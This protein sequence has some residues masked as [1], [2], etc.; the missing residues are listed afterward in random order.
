[1]GRAA[2]VLHGDVRREAR[3][4]GGAGGWGRVAAEEEG[5]GPANGRRRPLAFAGP[6][7]PTPASRRR[8]RPHPLPHGFAPRYSIVP[9][10]CPSRQT[11]RCLPADDPANA[12]WCL[13]L[14]CPI[15]RPRRVSGVHTEHSL[16]PQYHPQHCWRG[17]VLS[18]SVCRHGKA[19]GSSRSTH[20][21]RAPAASA[22]GGASAKRQ[23]RGKHEARPHP[24]APVK[25]LCMTVPRLS[26]TGRS[27]RSR[28]SEAGSTPRTWY[29]VAPTSSGE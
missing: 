11:R 27:W 7:G 24:A 15:R 20:L 12:P 29:T 28:T 13:A 21:R 23:A 19:G 16:W 22:S 6:P 25:R 8:S 4:R 9:G 26:C 17:Q 3:A 14:L 10:A 2:N 1:V 18:R 5:R